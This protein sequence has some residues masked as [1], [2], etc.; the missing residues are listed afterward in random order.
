MKLVR[1]LRGFDVY[2]PG[3]CA[4]FDDEKA[5]GL[6]MR[7]AAVYVETEVETPPP[8]AAAET[9]EIKEPPQDRMMRPERTKGHR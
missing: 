7:G 3:E 6:V 5:K 9:K 4:G 1:F 2:N 8:S